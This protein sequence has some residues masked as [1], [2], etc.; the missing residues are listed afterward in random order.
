MF[1]IYIGGGGDTVDDAALNWQSI[2][3][4]LSS[5]A[6]FSIFR[7]GLRSRLFNA[8]GTLSELRLKDRPFANFGLSGYSPESF[9]NWR[10]LVAVAELNCL[11]SRL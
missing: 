1:F 11:I 7:A 5:P 8:D 2:P 6:I 3:L 10:I 4:R 9:K